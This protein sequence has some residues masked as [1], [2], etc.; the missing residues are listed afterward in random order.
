MTLEEFLKLL[1]DPEK[2]I[3]EYGLG[4]EEVSYIDGV[5]DALKILNGGPVENTDGKYL[6]DN[7]EKRRSCK[8][9][10][11]YVAKWRGEYCTN[12]DTPKY[13]LDE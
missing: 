11:K 10:I 7:V 1:P 8:H 12:C 6:I 5:R 2:R 13:M 9:D 4:C 3:E